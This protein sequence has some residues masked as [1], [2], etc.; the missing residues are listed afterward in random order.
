MKQFSNFLSHIIQLPRGH[1]DRGIPRSA[2]LRSAV[3]GERGHAGRIPVRHEVG[4]SNQRW[5]Q[6]MIYES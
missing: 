4:D 2:G 1:Q 6:I 5:A 3:S